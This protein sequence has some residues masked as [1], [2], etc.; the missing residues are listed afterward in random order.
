MTTDTPKR[1]IPESCIKMHRL[2]PEEEHDKFQP[3]KL[4]LS[5]VTYKIYFVVLQ[6]AKLN[7]PTELLSTVFPIHSY[8]AFGHPQF[9]T[10][11]R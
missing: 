2:G 10:H 3:E 5:S 1:G 8:E 6:H 9:H 11:I 7:S 4:S